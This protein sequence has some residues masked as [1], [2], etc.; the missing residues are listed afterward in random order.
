MPKPLSTGRH[1]SDRKGVP[2]RVRDFTDGRPTFNDAAMLLRAALDGF[3]LAYLPDEMVRALID[4]G[5]LI[6][7]LERWCDRF[8]GSTSTTLAGVSFRRPSRCWSTPCVTGLQLMNDCR[9][10]PINRRNASARRAQQ[11]VARGWRTAF[12]RM[13]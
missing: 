8:S 3:D 2:D 6:R 10:F 4:E 12:R 5:R 7:V 13:G 11:P 1:T 9:P